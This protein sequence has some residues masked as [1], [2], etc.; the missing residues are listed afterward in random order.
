MTWRRWTSR[1]VLGAA[2]VSVPLMANAVMLH[3]KLSRSEPAANA[4]L[5]TSPTA[6]SDRHATSGAIRII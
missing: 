2:I 5:A 1:I 4:R 3:L 6:A